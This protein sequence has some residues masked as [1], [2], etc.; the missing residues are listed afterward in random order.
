MNTHVLRDSYLFA[1]LKDIWNINLYDYKLFKFLK[2]SKLEPS[3]NLFMSGMV[4]KV[5]SDLQ[6]LTLLSG[7]KLF[8]D[9]IM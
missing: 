8:W 4:S 3:I 2:F 1:F 7:S 6:L 5:M 9:S